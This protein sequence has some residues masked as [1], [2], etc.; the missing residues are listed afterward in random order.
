MKKNA[1]TLFCH[2]TNINTWTA[3]LRFTL[4]IGY[5]EVNFLDLTV[6]KGQRYNNSKI[7]DL[8]L[9]SKPT[10]LYLFTDP[11]SNIPNT[12]KFGWLTGEQIRYIRN[13][14]C[15]GDYL[16]SLSN[17]KRHLSNRKYKESVQNKYLFLDY[18]VS[19]RNSLLSKPT[20]IQK[21]AT[22]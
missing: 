14:S 6:L 9:Y 7:L 10:N 2:F 3:Y 16:D 21:Q 22:L 19:L 15:Y 12:Y 1:N 5:I 4:E 18:S 13:N 20:N 11:C 17:L 8:K